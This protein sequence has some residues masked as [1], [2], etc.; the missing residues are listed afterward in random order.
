MVG[1]CEEAFGINRMVDFES[2]IP[3]L[4]AFQTGS[5]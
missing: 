3:G 2:M 5:T 4:V 1:V